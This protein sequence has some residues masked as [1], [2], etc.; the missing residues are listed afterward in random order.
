MPKTGAIITTEKGNPIT[1]NPARV[2]F[3][4]DQLRTKTYSA[5]RDAIVARWGVHHTTAEKDIRAAKKLIALELD[6]IEVRAGEVRR[7]ERIADRAEELA[8]KAAKGAASAAELGAVAALQKTAI[9]AS[10]EVSRLTGAY[11][12]KEI[13]VTHGIAGEVPLQIDAVLAILSPAGR[14]HLEAVLDE[15]DAARVAGR[16]VDSAEAEDA[17]FTD[18]PADPPSSGTEN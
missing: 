2:V 3:A 1:R 17:E 5:A 7:N 4:A 15:I 14:E 8:E 6:A 16:L 12:P 11:A 10:R 13:K 9:A 18:L